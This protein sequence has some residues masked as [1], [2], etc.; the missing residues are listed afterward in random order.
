VDLD[1][2]K[3]QRKTLITQLTTTAPTRGSDCGYCGDLNAIAECSHGEVGVDFPIPAPQHPESP[4]SWIRLL[5]RITNN[6]T[7]PAMV[8]GDVY[9]ALVRTEVRDAFRHSG[10][11]AP[12][13]DY[14]YG[15]PFTDVRAF[16]AE[17][18]DN[19]V[20]LAINYGVARADGC[21]VGSMTFSGGH[22]VMFQGAQRRRVRYVSRRGRVYYRK[23][24]KSILSD[25]LF[26]GRKQ[27]GGQARY[28]KGH[29]IT[30]LYRYRRAAGAFGTAF[31]GTPRPI[32][33][34]RAVAI[35]IT[36][37]D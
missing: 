15:I 4:K 7:G 3:R 37:K 18:S 9:E 25:S 16:L 1:R 31:D 10:L 26:D 12:T 28:P 5:R 17:D 8:R 29:V 6:L 21:P 22:I 20:L 14:R 24:W 2:I 35:F 36:R 19:M 32:G 27:P 34:N 30:R 23:R 13:V 11:K 33:V